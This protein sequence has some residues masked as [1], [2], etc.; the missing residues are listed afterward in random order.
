[1][2][3]NGLSS[4]FTQMESLRESSRRQIIQTLLCALPIRKDLDVFRDFF[5]GLIGVAN[6]Q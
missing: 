3:A 2:D 5:A 4:D 6:L 1:V